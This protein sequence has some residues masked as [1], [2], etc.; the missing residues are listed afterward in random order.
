MPNRFEV[1]LD[2]RDVSIPLFL[3]RNHIH[4]GDMDKRRILNC[5]PNLVEYSPMTRDDL[6]TV[7][8]MRY[9]KW[10]AAESIA[11]VLENAAVTTIVDL[12]DVNTQRTTKPGL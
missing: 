8:Y 7:I 2:F 11:R 6:I 5:V 10:S 12:Q 3:E 9:K 4:M 1:T